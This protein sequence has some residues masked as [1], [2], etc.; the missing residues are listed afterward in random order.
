MDFEKI[1]FVILPRVM[2]IFLHTEPVPLSMLFDQRMSDSDILLSLRQVDPT[3]TS[4]FKV[5]NEKIS[6][7]MFWLKDCII[8]CQKHVRMAGLSKGLNF[9]L[10]LGSG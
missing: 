1:L 10:F 3:I 7:R 5:R 4:S 8:Y 9:L 2:N 6:Q